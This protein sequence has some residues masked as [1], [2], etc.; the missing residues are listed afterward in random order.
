M[1]R[2]IPGALGMRE[3]ATLYGSDTDARARQQPP[4]DRDTARAAA[5]ELRSRGLTPLDIAQALGLSE[6][7]VRALLEPTE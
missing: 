4:P 3:L 2:T 5:V 7:A 6:G 1:S